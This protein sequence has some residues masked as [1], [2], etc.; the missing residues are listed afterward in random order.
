MKSNTKMKPQVD[1]K[2][3]EVKTLREIDLEVGLP[4]KAYH[5]LRY[6]VAVIT[7]HNASGKGEKCIGCGIKLRNSLEKYIGDSPPCR[8]EGDSHVYGWNPDT[9][10]WLFI[11]K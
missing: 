10:N 1:N 9:K 8:D 7:E 2:A 6:T 11:S 3:A 5:Q 4:F